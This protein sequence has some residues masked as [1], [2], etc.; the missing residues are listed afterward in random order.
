VWSAAVVRAQKLEEQVEKE[1]MGMESLPGQGNF[2][3]EGEGGGEP[4]KLVKSIAGQGGVA[5]DHAPDGKAGG[6]EGKKLAQ[7]CA[8]KVW[9]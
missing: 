2:K 3:T 6:T 9:S 4:R 5:F 1:K 8:K 7:S